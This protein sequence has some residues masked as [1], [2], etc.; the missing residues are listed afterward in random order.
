M[1]LGKTQKP[2]QPQ[3][4]IDGVVRRQ[5]DTK[6]RPLNKAWFGLAAIAVAAVVILG[7]LSMYHLS[8]SATR[9]SVDNDRYQAVHVADGRVFFGKIEHIDSHFIRL[10]EAYYTPSASTVAAGDDAANQNTNLS[11]I[12][13][14]EEV[15]GPDGNV[16]LQIEQVVYWENLKS[17]SKLLQAIGK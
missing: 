3:R 8:G 5:H 13:A 2:S 11:L 17:D 14:G 6:Q 1:K 10:A 9:R 16:L 12:K 15:Y 7:L 4:T